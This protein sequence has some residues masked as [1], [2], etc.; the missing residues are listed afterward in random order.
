MSFLLN[1]KCLKLLGLCLF[2]AQRIFISNTWIPESITSHAW[3]TAVFPEEHIFMLIETKKIYLPYWN[4]GK[5]HVCF[6]PG[7]RIGTYT[8]SVWN[9]KEKDTICYS[10]YVCYAMTYVIPHDRPIRNIW[11]VMEC[12]YAWSLCCP[13]IV[14]YV[15]LDKSISSDLH[16]CK[17]YTLYNTCPYFPVY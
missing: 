14:L 11:N 16:K 8:I 6:M 15:T 7:Q 1:R 10:M 12:Q 17:S 9:M 4:R 5:E 3:S 13:R 2:V